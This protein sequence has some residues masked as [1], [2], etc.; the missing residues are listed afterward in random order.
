[1]TTAVRVL[2]WAGDPTGPPPAGP[3]RGAAALVSPGEQAVAALRRLAALAAARLGA[4][5]P[6]LADPGPVG[7]G[8]LLLAAAIG[9]R[10]ERNAAAAIIDAVPAIRLGSSG[11]WV[12]SVARH[13]VVAPLMISPGIGLDDVTADTLL[14]ASPL[15][16]VLYRPASGTAPA[17]R[18]VAARLLAR[19]RGAGIAVPAL[20]APSAS[21][22][23]LNWRAELLEMMRLQHTACALDVY[24]AAR[25]WHGTAWDDRLRWAEHQLAGPGAQPELPI[26]TIRYWVPLARL[27]RDEQARN[28]LGRR[29]AA[30]QSEAARGAP[31]IAD[32]I[33]LRPEDYLPAVRLVHRFR[34][35]QAAAV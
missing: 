26:A 29:I 34:L 5:R 4:G 14:R 12:D 3:L 8:S 10:A 2:D 31:S 32:R 33:L 35:L 13:A 7:P 11:A 25:L 24:L 17:A 23:I 27:Y 19:P 1:M 16:G 21:A 6:P 9:G 20:A 28:T 30:G 22:E 18:T 15:T